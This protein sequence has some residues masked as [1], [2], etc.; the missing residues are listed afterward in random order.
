LRDI[1]D[2]IAPEPIFH[3]VAEALALGVPFCMHIDADGA[4]SGFLDLGASCQ[5]M[6]GVPGEAL[7]ADY[8]VLGE[9]IVP[10]DRERVMSAKIA[11]AGRGPWSTEFRVRKPSGE[12]RWVRM[13]AA[14]RPAGDDSWLLD[15]LLVDITE[16]R[17]MAEQL[18][19]ERLRLEQAIELT[20]MGVF[21]WVRD[22]PD[23]VLWSDAQYEIFGLPP[24]TPMT[25]AAARALVHP[26]D[27]KEGPAGT[28]FPAVDDCD[29]WSEHR[30]VRGDGEVRWVAV[31]SRKR[32]DAAGL[33]SI[34]GVT[35]DVTDRHSAEEQ[36]RLQMR[37]LTHRAKNG[38]TVLMAMVQQ[39]ARSAKTVEDLSA[40]IMSRLM[41]M[42]KSQE[43]A[44]ASG[45]EQLQL[46][47][48][49]RVVLEAFD[50]A[51][52]DIDEA[53]ATLVL[54]ERSGI[55][56][57]LLLHELATNAVKYGALSNPVGRVA[58]SL[59]DRRDGW[60]VLEWRE[61]GGPP[62]SPPPRSGF[63]MRLLATAMQSHGGSVTPAFEHD[64][65]VARIVMAV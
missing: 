18:A 28:E 49:M 17:R 63:G 65:F 25:V 48:L 10:E 11:L 29:P 38:L 50:L 46:T 47:A 61:T 3:D 9:L 33:K 16:S 12:L 23:T 8:R 5:E 22:D 27:Q 24:Q 45:S 57:A 2:R 44:T 55:M 54:K 42:A 14:S 41:A 6:L 4:P 56:L 58:I 26:D 40:L 35:I 59:E 36:R 53:L 62:V 34:Q 51:R 32:R 30:I 31:H 60:T 15:G 43:L 19:D 20:G 13:T 64:G 39:A 7:L 52:F 37:E 21:T 1:R